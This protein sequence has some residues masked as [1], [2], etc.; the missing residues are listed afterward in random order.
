MTDTFIISTL[1]VILIGVLGYLGKRMLD[2]LSELRKD[3][4]EHIQDDANRLARLEE[5][6]DALNKAPCLESE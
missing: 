5:K 6:V 3:F 4:H 1:I 2:E